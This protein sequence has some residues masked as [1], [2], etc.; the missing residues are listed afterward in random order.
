MGQTWSLFAFFSQ[1]CDKYSTNLTINDKSV[2][3]V[4]GT[5]VCCSRMENADKSTELLS[6]N[7]PFKYGAG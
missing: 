2:D 3:G 5:R 4:L 7:V 1:C 6:L